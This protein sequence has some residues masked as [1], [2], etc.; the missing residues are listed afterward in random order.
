M[1]IL[2]GKVRRGFV[3]SNRG[4]EVRRVESGSRG[5]GLGVRRVESVR[6]WGVFFGDIGR[7]V[8]T[9]EEA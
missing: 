2:V 7:V 1:I 8:F 5:W 4:L 3:G 6:G 9:V